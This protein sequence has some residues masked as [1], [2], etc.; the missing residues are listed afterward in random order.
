MQCSNK[1]A[2]NLFLLHFISLMQSMLSLIIES[3]S[4]IIYDR[5]IVENRVGMVIRIEERKTRRIHTDFTLFNSVPT[6]T[7]TTT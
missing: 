5:H 6:S 7:V 2:R 3:G 4:M 1:C